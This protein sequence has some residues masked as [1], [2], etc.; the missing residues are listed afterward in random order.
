MNVVVTGAC[1]FI[2]GHLVK[3]IVREHPDWNI[4]CIDDYSSGAP[5]RHSSVGNV[6][7]VNASTEQI[8]EVCGGFVNV[9]F[10]LGEY[11][12]IVPSFIDVERCFRSNGWGTFNVINFCAKHGAKLVYA[13]SSSKFGNN[14]EDENL[15]PYA[16]TKAKNI[17]LIRNYAKWF[18][19]KAA[20]TYFFNVYGPEHI[21]KGNYATV[22]GIF[23]Q[24][25]IDGEPLSVVAP[26]TQTRDFTHVDDIVAGLL[27]AAE[28]GTVEH[29]YLLGSGK[30]HTILEIASAFNHPHKIWP[31][32]RG[33][34]LSGQA[35]TGAALTHLGWEA[36]HDV[37]EYIASWKAEYDAAHV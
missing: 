16:W 12:R 14:G 4:I 18:R 33:E 15:S 28:K 26:G 10:H 35:M 30:E 32:R 34:R 5:T 36:K 6:L 21:R 11:S 2:G 27:L 24:C 13:A 7:Y 23:E 19:L 22:I 37:M 9:V 8:E 20:I 29:D 17:E 3:A 31:E 1:G 25:V